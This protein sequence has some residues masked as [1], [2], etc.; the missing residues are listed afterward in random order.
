MKD[1]SSLT[2]PGQDYTLF[3]F[4]EKTRLTLV[5]AAALLYK[6]RRKKDGR[7]V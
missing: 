5:Q 6:G 2:P 7:P 4:S 1:Q 3:H